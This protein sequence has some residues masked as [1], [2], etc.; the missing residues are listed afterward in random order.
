[1]GTAR[2]PGDQYFDND[3]DRDRYF[4]DREKRDD[5]QPDHRAT[6]QSGYTAGRNAPDPSLRFESHNQ[7]Y[8]GRYTDPAGDDERFTGRGGEDHW[9]DRVEGKPGGQ[10]GLPGYGQQ[11]MYGYGQEGFTNRN[12]EYLSAWSQGQHPEPMGGHRGKA[13]QGYVRT[14]DRIREDAC[15]ALADDDHVDPT[16][17]EVVV[18]NGDI[19]LTGTV[20]DR[21]MKKRA[22]LIVER[23]S[24]VHDVQNHL[25]IAGNRTVEEAVGIQETEVP[26]RKHRA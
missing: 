10:Q 9:I 15:Q 13:P 6:G 3:S 17:V 8:A 2:K 18:Q 14:D 12:R 25:R 5:D 20:D 21:R 19:Y 1:M 4:M 23:V 26:D 24:G 22:E 7:A 11:T 16:H